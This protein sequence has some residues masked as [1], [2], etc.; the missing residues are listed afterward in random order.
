LTKL[1][2]AVIGNPISH[3]LSPQIHQLFAEQL[4][5]NINYTK[6]WA[7]LDGF[8]ATA[9]E[10]RAQGGQGLNVTAPFKNQAFQW[11]DKASE[12]ASL[13]QAVNTIIFQK[14]GTSFGDNTDGVG[15]VKDLTENYHCPITNQAILVLGAGG[16]A[17]G[18][19]AQLLQK[20]P[21][22][23]N[24]AN[25]SIDKAMN[26]ARQFAQQG[27]INPSSFIELAQQKFD[28]IINCIPNQ[29]IPDV[30]AELP[31]K[32]V[33]KALCYDMNYL[34]STTALQHWA[35]S[36]GARKAVDGV[37]MLLE[38]AAEAFYLWHGIRPNTTVVKLI[39]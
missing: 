27:K 7:P 19:L 26:L 21:A 8:A 32:L 28:V 23:L 3:S 10:F 38:Q 12:R 11:V 13:A 17:Q 4:D 35:I 9:C 31:L 6:L 22:K 29:A 36:Q 37:G 25:R 39:R 16:A 24:I 1:H 2:Y 20:Q 33:E 18:C 5:I 34:P 15:L 14:D 30:L